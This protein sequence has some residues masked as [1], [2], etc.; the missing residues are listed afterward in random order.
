MDGRLRSGPVGAD[1]G[2]AVRSGFVSY[3]KVLLVVTNSTTFDADADVTISCRLWL[4]CPILSPC[5]VY[6]G[7]LSCLRLWLLASCSLLC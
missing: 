1:S 3:V 7:W 4:E 5:L 6:Y 2:L